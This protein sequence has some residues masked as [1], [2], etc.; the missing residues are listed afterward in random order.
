V[1]TNAHVVRDLRPLVETAAGYARGRLLARDEGRD[2]AAIRVDLT[3]LETQ[4][5]QVRETASLR[6]GELVLAIGNPL[7]MSG[8]VASGVLQRAGPRFVVSD[9]R[10]APGN[11]GGP[12]AD[13]AGLVVGIN[14]MIAGRLAF[15]VPSEAVHAF[16]AEG[17]FVW[18]AA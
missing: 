6:C 1:I 18:R 8:A 3:G 10:L 9:V 5:V 7:G 2:L 11:S 15:A 14:S 4:P 12:L 13:A 17:G 16:L